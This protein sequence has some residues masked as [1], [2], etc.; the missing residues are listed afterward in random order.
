MPAPTLSLTEYAVL[1]VLA[2]RPAHGFAIA[3][4]FDSGGDLGKVMTVRR[5][6][7]Y[8]A[9]DRL[10]T[11]G[12]ARPA[13]SEPGDSGPQRVVLEITPAGRRRIDRWRQQPVA[14]VR[15]MRIEFQLKLALLQRSGESPLRLIRAQ[16][17]ALRPTLT[18]LED[19][20]VEDLD[21]LELWRQHNARAA[22]DYLAHLEKLYGS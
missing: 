17:E 19:P 5:S 21:H 15:E 4:N 12:L 6:L 22:G 7:V 14:H 13:K 10:V 18:A 1:A 2:E 9:L 3:R 16:Q 20:P 8:R 11:A